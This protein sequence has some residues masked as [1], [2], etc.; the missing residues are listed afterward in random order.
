MNPRLFQTLTLLLILASSLAAQTPDPAP[1]VEKALAA[2]GG[3]DK[4]LKIFRIEEVFHFGSTPEPE[5]GKKRST[6]TSVIEQP[7]LWWIGKKERADEPA[8]HDV[9]AWSLDL[10]IDPASKI[11]GIPDLVDEGRDCSGLQAS[12]SVTP[13]MKFYFDKQTHLLQR[14]D[15]RGDFYRFS[16]WREHDGLRYAAKTVIFKLAGGKPWFFHDITALQRLSELP[17]GLSKP[18]EPKP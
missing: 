9:R 5:A 13:P 10:L 15:W 8:K 4:L 1:V 3:R 18:T 17:P 12:G 6:R 7:A 16:D 14:L 2:V 11:E